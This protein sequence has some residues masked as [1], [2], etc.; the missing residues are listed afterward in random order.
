M[1]YLIDMTAQTKPTLTML[2]GRQAFDLDSLVA[3]F[4]RMTGRTPSDADKEECRAMLAAHK[5][6]REGRSVP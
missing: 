4:E 2:Q 5:A 1:I 3:M 6:Q